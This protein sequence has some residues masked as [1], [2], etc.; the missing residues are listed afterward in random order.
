MAYRGQDQKVQTVMVQPIVAF[1][2]PGSDGG[3]G[4][5]R[6]GPQGSRPGP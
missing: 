4:G 5:G 6:P 1:L 2:R 3:A